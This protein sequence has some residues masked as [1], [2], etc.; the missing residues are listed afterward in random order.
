MK[1]LQV[2]KYADL[3]DSLAFNEV[4]KPTFQAKDVLIEI[5]A[6]AINPIDKGIVQGHLK[7]ILALQLPATLGY[8]VSGIVTEKG[9]DVNNIEVGDEVYARVPQEQMGTLTEFVAVVSSAV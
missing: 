1:A 3:K 8:D 2:T 9:K 7:Q 5:K 4:T 6:A